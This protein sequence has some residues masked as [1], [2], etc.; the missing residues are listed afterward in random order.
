MSTQDKIVK[1]VEIKAP[2]SRVWQALTDYRQF[3]QWFCVDLNEPF[4]PGSRSTGLTTYPGY[5]GHEW[6]AQIE[7]MTPETLF[8]FRWHHD[9]I[10]PGLPPA[11]QP[12]TRVEFRLQATGDGT[13]LTITESGFAALPETK[14]IE[15][16]RLNTQGWDIQAKQIS[17]Y[18]LA[19]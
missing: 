10:E 9:D 13:R 8:S 3:G 5:E 4:A 16:I 6:L 15:A 17:D 11:Q 18:V 7:T 19:H 1:V 14:R 12:T 2:V